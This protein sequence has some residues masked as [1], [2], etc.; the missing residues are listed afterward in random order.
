MPREAVKVITLPNSR[1]ASRQKQKNNNNSDNSSS[2]GE[3]TVQ[4]K[5]NRII[6]ENSIDEDYVADVQ[7]ADIGKD[8]PFSSFQQNI[9]SENTLISFPKKSAAPIAQA[10]APN[11]A[12][13]D[14]EISSAP[15][16]DHISNPVVTLSI[17]RDD[18]QAA[19]ALNAASK[20]LKKFTTNKTLIEAVN[21][22]FLEIYGS[23]TGK[24]CMTGSGNAKRLVIHF[25]TA[26]A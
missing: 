12:S 23:Y 1:K 19:A 20:T 10:T 18:F 5:C 6:T 9:S 11:N 17:I 16:G 3:N 14:L 24:V 13:P 4:Q 26:K 22:L 21:N 2:D 7:M 25:Y 15:S 8:S